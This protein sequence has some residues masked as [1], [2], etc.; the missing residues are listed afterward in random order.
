MS[1]KRGLLEAFA[2]R[3]AKIAVI[4][5]GYVGLPLG[6][7]FA[8]KGFAVLGFDVDP[9]KIAALRDGRCYIQ[10]IDAGA[11]ARRSCEAQRFSATADFGALR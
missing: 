4:G 9:A 10:H 1:L 7:A 6:L 2:R 5:L 11:C 3:Q 8:E